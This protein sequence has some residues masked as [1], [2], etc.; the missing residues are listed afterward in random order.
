MTMKL[1]TPIDVNITTLY[2]LIFF[3]QLEL[4][5]V[6]GKQMCVMVYSC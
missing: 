1:K 3:Q 2:F 5:R 6:T 4:F